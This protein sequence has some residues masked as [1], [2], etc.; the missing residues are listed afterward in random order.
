[1]TSTALLTDH[2]E[3]TMLQAAL[4]SGM[5]HRR[6][7]FELFPR[8]L[9]EGRRYGVVAGV[10]RALDAIEAFT[11]DDEALAALEGVVNEETREWL[12]SYRFA[13]DVWG[14]AE[15]EAY[16]PYSPLLIV[17]G[18]FAEAVVLET[19]LL[20]IYNHDSAIASAAS[21][22][23]MAAG[24]RPCI[25]M[26]SRRTHEEAAV[27]SARAAYLAGFA[28]TSNL[29]ARQ[30]YGVPSAGTSAHSFTLLH[31]SEADAFRAQV[32]SLGAGTTLLV[33][34]YD[35]QEA[36]RAGVEIAGPGLGAVR[37]DSG[38]LGVLAHRVR[39]QLDDLGATKTR[40]VVTSDLDEY[41][42]AALAAAPV[43]GYGVGTQLVTGSGHPTCGFV[44]KLVA[45]EGDDGAMVS[46]AKK[47]PEKISIGGRKFALA[48][49]R[50]AGRGRGRGRRHRHPARERRQRPAAPRRAGPRRRGRR[51]RAARRRPG[52]ARRRTRG[53][54]VV[55][56]ADV[57]GRAGHPDDLSRGPSRGPPGRL[58]V[59]ALVTCDF[60]SDVL[61]VG[62]SMT[63]VLP[64]PTEEQ[65][66]VEGDAVPRTDFPVLYLLHGLS[67]DHTAWLRYTSVERYAAAAGVAV[68]MP[69]VNRSFYANEVSGGRYWDYVAEELPQIV[70]NFF[71]VSQDPAQ[72]Y[73][74]GLIMGGYG[75][76][77][78]A[79]THPDRFAA[80]ATL[81]GA[82]D[83]DE[84]SSRPERVDLFERI[85]G[86]IDPRRR[87]PLQA[88]REGRRRRASPASTSPPAPRTPPAWSRATAASSPCWRTRAPT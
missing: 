5:A 69:A 63:V 73:V 74:A 50:R 32:T 27:A 17:E 19:L 79:L 36:V 76:M 35:V 46:V 78:L 37:L 65:I 48:P 53:A 16:F 58:T 15:G 57:E 49:A 24:D 22:M 29:A 20:S 80:A 70:G 51:P 41:A 8:R 55:G 4:G 62:C 39:K 10:G 66:G 28:S 6:S 54:P 61:E 33:D 81:S 86:D 72:T 67:D 14:Y 25:E 2:Y 44:Y 87:R 1:M 38:D 34:T 9:P 11:F 52:P 30:R 43:D 85:F 77:K 40:I 83:L 7:V 42:I 56:P 84:L 13:G 88:A 23:T 45:R 60:F 18:T 59:M 21:R 26:G 12:A 71:R 64:Q 75:A 82:L 47:S 31:D 3:L 68:V